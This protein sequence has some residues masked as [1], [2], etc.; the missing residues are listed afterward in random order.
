MSKENDPATSSP[1]ECPIVCPACGGKLIIKHLNCADCDTEVT[2]E[3]ELPPLARLS[4][5]DLRYIIDYI[6]LN[7]NLKEMAAHM[8]VSYP[9]A[10][11]RFS[12][13]IR[14]LNSKGF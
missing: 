5:K 10:R 4:E 2:G 3:F 14:M 11:N 13:I 7:G 9:T 6:K 8:N 12:R 1:V